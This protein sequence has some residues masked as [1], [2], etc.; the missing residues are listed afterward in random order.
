MGVLDVYNFKKYKNLVFN[1]FFAI[2]HHPARMFENKTLTLL[3][4]EKRIAAVRYRFNLHNNSN[5]QI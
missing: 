3:Q 1:F 2:C 5:H 4:L